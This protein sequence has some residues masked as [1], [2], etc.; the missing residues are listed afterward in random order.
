MFPDFFTEKSGFKNILTAKAGDLILKL[1]DKAKN[2]G[3]SLRITF[4]MMLV[5]S[6]SI[7][8]I[9]LI[10]TYGT[11]KSFHALSDATDTYI[12]LQDAASS[13]MDASDLLTEEA[14]CY[15]VVGTRNHLDNYF[16]EADNTKRREQAVEVMEQQ[17]PESE[18]LAELKGA[19]QESYTLMEKEFYAMKLIL[20]AQND[21]D[22]PD[23]LQRV[24]LSAEDRALSA[25]GKQRRAEVILHDKGYYAQKNMIRMHL[26]NCIEQ[27][28]NGTH[29]TQLETQKALSNDLIL[30]T[31]MI[32]IQSLSIV[33]ILFLTT[34]LGINPLLRAVERINHD[35]SLP[36][37]G[38]YEFRY[39]ARTYNK[40]YSA[41][42]RSI[43]NLSF[44]ASHDEL[45]G[46][47]NRAGYDL[48]KQSVDLSTSAFLLFDVDHFKSI[49]DTYGHETGD[50]ALQKLASS[51]KQNFRAD[52]YIC[53]IGGDEFVVIMVHVNSDSRPLIENKVL[54]INRNLQ[55][56][57][58]LPPFTVSVG[59]SLCSSSKDA[60]QVFHEADVALYHVK[61]GGRNGICFY[62][63][64]IE[65]TGS[66]SPA[67][68]VSKLA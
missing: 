67:G 40:M 12:N 11:I 55:Q 10:S 21:P 23:A 52:D 46:V 64:G 66:E 6:V 17:L 62:T 29:G 18:A 28:K 32:I 53:R 45:T 51:I 57:S 15:S 47:Y 13:L 2:E 41:Y 31:V 38:A 50:R 59:V 8:I 65:K 5:F 19:M 22:V 24:E 49:N 43:K 44:K 25:E 1:L 42:K 37:M 48:I 54:T 63:P 33:L 4:I 3:L 14:Q 34:R 56:D 7:T 20:E 35:E 60:L 58:D 30:I 36:I 26:S 16:N 9:L 39:L 68:S 61:D 27:L